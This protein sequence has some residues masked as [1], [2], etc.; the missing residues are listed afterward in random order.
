MITKTY[1]EFIQHYRPWP[2]CGFDG[3]TVRLSVRR[4]L[5]EGL[6]EKDEAQIEISIEETKGNR[7]FR[8][9][10]SFVLAPSV[11]D[12]FIRSMTDHNAPKELVEWTFA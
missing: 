11:I 7:V 2:G 4:C 12:L 9:Y 6:G 10:A 5:R 3:K 8:H 1:T